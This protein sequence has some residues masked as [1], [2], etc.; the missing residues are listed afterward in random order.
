MRGLAVD[1]EVDKLFMADTKQQRIAVTSLD[2]S[3]A[4]INITTTPAGVY[5]LAAERKKR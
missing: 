3:G 4:L 1:P 5:S 2:G